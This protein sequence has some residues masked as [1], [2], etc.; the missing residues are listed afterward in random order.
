MQVDTM[1]CLTARGQ[2]DNV[3][4]P[5]TAEARKQDLEKPKSIL[6]F[7]HSRQSVFIFITKWDKDV[8]CSNCSSILVSFLDIGH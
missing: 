4:F 5:K 8:C 1:Y 6:L 2:G 3:L 7:Q